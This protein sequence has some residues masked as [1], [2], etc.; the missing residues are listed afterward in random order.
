MMGWIALAAIGAVAFGL[1]WLFGMPRALGSFS[2]A[3]LMLG[4]AGYALQANP[5]LS[6]APVST[7]KKAQE[8]DAA[9]RDLRG[10]M[11]GRFSYLD[12][13]FFAAD[14]LV[15][16]GDPDKAT[17]LMLGGVRSSPGDAA[18]WTWLGMTM[19]EADKRT[20][21]PAAG[22]AF[23]RAVA[24]AP[25]HPG[26]AFFYGLAHVRA[27]DYAAARPWWRKALS[28]SPVGAPYRRDIAVRLALLEQFLKLEA[29]AAKAPPTR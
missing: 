10:A 3:A 12:S 27:G 13:Y 14:S 18:M 26:P 2:G 28:L 8:D 4:A 19:V 21:S 23:R 9:L 7:V 22:L 1:L 15:R 29:E 11:F 16:G 25:Q 17:R 5:G 6:G 24:L 20:V